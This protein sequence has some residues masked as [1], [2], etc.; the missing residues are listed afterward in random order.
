MHTEGPGIWGNGELYWK[1]MEKYL[2]YY[3]EDGGGEIHTLDFFH[4]AV[5]NSFFMI[6]H[7]LETAR[8]DIQDEIEWK[9]T[10]V[11]SIHDYLCWWCYFILLDRCGVH[12][13]KTEVFSDLEK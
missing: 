6:D 1:C 7:A 9:N 12:T 3:A 4:H 8:Q 10:M 2:E 13:V 11:G 5:G